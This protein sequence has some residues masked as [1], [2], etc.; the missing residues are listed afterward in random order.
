[1]DFFFFL[2]NML[3]NDENAYH[4]K[5]FQNIPILESRDR[6]HPPPI[7]PYWG[8]RMNLKVPVAI[9]SLGCVFLSTGAKTVLVVVATPPTEN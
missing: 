7:S 9:L 2:L 3:E 6:T 5:Y 4:F 1:M 8:E